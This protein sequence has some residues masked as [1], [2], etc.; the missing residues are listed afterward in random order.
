MKCSGAEGRD[1]ASA[2]S[3]NER[4]HLAIGVITSQVC[5][6]EHDQILIKESSEE[7]S[8]DIRKDDQKLE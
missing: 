3:C 7:N 6:I 5:I 8:E 1:Y 2:F 4:F